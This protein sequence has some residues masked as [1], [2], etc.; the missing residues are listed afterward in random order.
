[1]SLG[2]A[3]C[4]DFL[5]QLAQLIG[6]VRFLN[7]AASGSIRTKTRVLYGVR[8]R[9]QSLENADIRRQSWSSGSSTRAL[10]KF[11]LTR[12]APSASND[13]T[14]AVPAADTIDLANW[15]HDYVGEGWAD[16]KATNR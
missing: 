15:K 12:H 11:G 8:H 3:G 13:V 14:I 10:A 1:L 16:T 5:K 9:C 2:L 7:P 6:K 4:F